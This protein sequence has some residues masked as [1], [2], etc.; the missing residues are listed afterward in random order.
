MTLFKKM[1]ASLPGN[2]VRPSA[3][4]GVNLTRQSIDNNPFLEMDAQGASQRMTR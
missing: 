4:P 3:G 1:S 2:R